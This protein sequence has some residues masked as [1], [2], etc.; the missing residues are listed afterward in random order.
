VWRFPLATT[1]TT[2]TTTSMVWM[3]PRLLVMA[4]GLPGGEG[5]AGHRRLPGELVGSDSHWWNPDLMVVE[6][7][8]VVVLQGGI[9]E[10]LRRPG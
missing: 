3:I 6:V 1:T 4:R 7:L 2:T 9:R 5:Q 10:R 8:Q